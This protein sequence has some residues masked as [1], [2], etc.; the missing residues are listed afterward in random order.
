MAQSSDGQYDR[1]DVRGASRNPGRH[2]MRA[3][4][5]HEAWILLP[6]HT[7]CVQH[8][9]VFQD[10]SETCDLCPV[11]GAC[12]VLMHPESAHFAVV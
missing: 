1:H 7:H 5:V 10:G 9:S 6:P 2:L 8:P 3:F 11:E 4:L 12:L